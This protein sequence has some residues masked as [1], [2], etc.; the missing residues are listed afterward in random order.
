MNKLYI[1]LAVVILSAIGLTSQADAAVL[2]LR[3]NATTWAAASSWSNVGAADNTDSGPCTASDTCIAEL[4]SGNVSISAT[5][6]AGSFS[7]TAGTGSWGGTLTHDAGI[8]WTV[9]GNIT[10]NAGMTYTPTATSTVTLAANNTL[11]SAGKL[12]PLVISNTGIT[13]TLG[14]N[15]SF[16]ASKVITLTL[17]GNSLAL[18]G[19]TIAGNSATNR[20]L[21]RSNTLGTART[22]TNTTGT[23]ANADF[24][25][26]TFSTVADYSAIAGGSGDC[27]GNTNGTFTTA[28]TNYWIGGTGSWS[29]VNEWASSS[30]G[31]GA[32]GRVPL[33]QDGARF[34]VNSFSAGGQTVTQDMPRIGKDVDW[35]GVTNTPTW[36]TNTIAQTI[37]GSL[38]LVSGMTFTTGSTGTWIFEGRSDVYLTSAGKTFATS[39]QIN[40]GTGNGVTLL[41]AFT[42]T[43]SGFLL[44]NGDF[45]ANDFSVTIGS[46]VRLKY[47]PSSPFYYDGG[48]SV[49]NMGS[50]T[51]TFSGTSALEGPWRS[52][53]TSRPSTGT[54][55]L[56]AEE[57]IIYFSDV[58]GTSKNFTASGTTT[59]NDLKIKGGGAGAVVI[60]G[61]NTFNRIYTD[62]GGTKSVTLPGSTTTTIL[63]GLG[64]NNGTNL[65]TFTASAGSA[66]LAKSGSGNVDWDYVSLTNIIAST[67][68][69]WYAGTHST[70]GG[71]NTNWIF[72][73][74]PQTH[75]GTFIGDE[76]QL[77]YK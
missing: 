17:N 7:T 11:T 28:Q 33:P 64:L 18:N 39:F 72:S 22:L 20:V 56:N 58:S 77:I 48:H 12:F 47:N 62:G 36:S 67:T 76:E 69:T 16:M 75:L 24:R 26:I 70:N 30:G 9:S 34:D 1:S 40:K 2:Y 38:T 19:F 61:T 46:Y 52:D 53:T 23:F 51:W 10:F 35:T 14:D 43:T 8:V 50:G 15:L 55:T 31:A 63:S 21:I 49:L 37:Y 41:D 5:A 57:S 59:F 29:D 27:G 6:A 44:L 45:D 66:T 68:N 25:D 32:S 3:D 13:T 54:L 42:I 73:E 74:A 65:I 60:A 71:G 4:L